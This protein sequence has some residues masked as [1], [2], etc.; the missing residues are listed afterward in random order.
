MF[1]MVPFLLALFA[2]TASTLTTR[3]SGVWQHTKIYVDCEA[4]G[5]S[6]LPCGSSVGEPCSSLEAALEAV[7][8]QQSPP[9]A[10][11][12]QC[13]TIEVLPGRCSGSENTDISFEKEGEPGSSALDDVGTVIKI[14]GSSSNP[15]RTVLDCGCD[16]KD[17]CADGNSTR[18]FIMSPSGIV[19]ISGMTIINCGGSGSSMKEEEVGLLLFCFSALR[20]H[21]RSLT[22]LS[23]YQPNLSFSNAQRCSCL[24]TST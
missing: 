19:S 5:P 24:P 6:A 14:Q 7:R 20:P 16:F 9:S 8:E 11:A 15:S 17:T 4:S 13:V 2:I 18:A 12:R 22:N 10:A 23:V 21:W 3:D 1:M